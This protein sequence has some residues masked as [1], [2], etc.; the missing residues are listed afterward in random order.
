MIIVQVNVKTK[1]NF[2]RTKKYLKKL[3]KKLKLLIMLLIIYIFFF[4]RREDC[5]SLLNLR[6]NGKSNKSRLYKGWFTGFAD[7]I[8]K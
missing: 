2:I 8:S 5:F 1:L 4:Y 6:K 3:A 7:H